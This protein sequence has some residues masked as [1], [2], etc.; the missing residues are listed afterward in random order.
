MPKKPLQFEEALEKLEQIVREL[1]EGEIGLEA[2]LAR[3]EEGVQFLRQCYGILQN[4]ERR[5]ELLTGVDANGQPTTEPFDAT[6]TVEQPDGR[7]PSR[8]QPSSEVEED[9]DETDSGRLF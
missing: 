7:P 6:A 3:Y 9:D 1:E 2:S 8:P 5:I 4:A